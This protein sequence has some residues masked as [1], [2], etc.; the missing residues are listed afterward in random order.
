VAYRF[1]REPARLWHGVWAKTAAGAIAYVRVLACLRHVLPTAVSVRILNSM[2]QV[3]WPEVRMPAYRTVVG[4]QT[5]LRLHPH[6]EEFDLAILLTP[7]L[8]YEREVFAWLESRVGEFDVIV[9]IGANV[10]VFTAFF[11][12]RLVAA[13]RPDARVFAFEPSTRAF[14][15]LIENIDANQLSNVT[16]FNVALG[17]EVGLRDFYEPTGHLTNGSLVREF[18]GQFSAEVVARKVVTISGAEVEA[19]VPAHS[20]VLLKIDVEGAEAEV[21][22]GL[23]GFIARYK[24]HIVLEVLAGF[25]ERIQATQALTSGAYRFFE[26]EATGAVERPQ[27]KAG[28]GRDWWLE[29]R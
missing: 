11:G 23:S 12:A 16:A 26:L 7:V 1:L 5:P 13:G 21:L 22:D 28:D 20:R 15:R 9:E 10:G 6:F 27:L 17:S 3:S 25:E 14:H 18:A 29:P 19:L 2:G 24:P 8:S 4:K